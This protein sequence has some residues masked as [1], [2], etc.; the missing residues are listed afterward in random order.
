LY[1]RELPSFE[2]A[3]TFAAEDGS[4]DIDAIRRRSNERKLL[5]TFAVAVFAAVA[6]AVLLAYAG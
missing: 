5:A 2:P 4:Q 6:V 1:I 3:G